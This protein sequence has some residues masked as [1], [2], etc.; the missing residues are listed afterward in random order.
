[1]LT[2]YRRHLKNCRRRDEG[3]SYR[4]CRCP[5]WVDGILGGAEIRESL[6][7]RDW[8]R[9]QEI[10]REWEIE[11]RRT[12]Q[13][14]RKSM[15]EAWKEFLADIEARKLNDST[16]RK[17]KVLNRQMEEFAQ[18][19][20]LRVLADFDL[21]KVSQ[22]RGEWK[23]GS[24]SSAKKLE[25]LRAFFRFAQKRKWVPEN[26]ADDLKAPKITLCPTLPFS[27]EE[28][29]RILAAIE[30]YKDEFAERGAE[31][32]RRMRALVLLIRYAGMR[33][34]DTVSM[35]SERIEGNRLFLY[36]QKT[37]VP[38]NTVLPDFVLKAL[39]EMPKT[40][41]TLFFWDGT[42]KL[43]TIVGSWRKRMVRLFEIA[44]VE[45]GHP[46]RFGD[47]FAV[48][49]LLSGMPIER[50]SILLGH[51]SVRITEKHYSPWVRERQDQLEAD[52]SRAWSRDPVILAETG[53]TRRVHEEIGNRKPLIPKQGKWRRGW[54]S[55]PRME[56]LQTSP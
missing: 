43:E 31:N 33:M 9:A 26:P 1:M 37:G 40:T 7:V 4:N 46:H 28:M 38:V 52:L 8:Q 32:A 17:Y 39:D 13:L 19:R 11:N 36:T 15:Q 48:E 10:I 24:R 34:G 47:T 22:F 12:S 21:S 16:A 5:I 42:S 30:K 56:V 14:T 41:D 27:R 23:D 51:S 50:V 25:R 20:G 3:R 29:L 35:G 55:N 44:K 2:A 45:D 53:G 54:D 49:L 6:K 18:R